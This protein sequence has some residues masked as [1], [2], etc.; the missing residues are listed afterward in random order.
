VS[1]FPS[2]AFFYRADIDSRV[3]IPFE[4]M[5]GQELYLGAVEADGLIVGT[6]RRETAVVNVFVFDFPSTTSYD[7]DT[8]RLVDPAPFLM[9]G[10][11]VV[12]A[13]GAHAWRVP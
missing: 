11:W 13:D 8:S 7:L 12:T 10:R 6:V 9:A 5:P 2:H 1:Y 4:V 3:D